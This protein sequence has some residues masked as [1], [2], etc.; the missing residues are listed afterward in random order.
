MNLLVILN[1]K[2]DTPAETFSQ[3]AIDIMPEPVAMQLL[4]DMADVTKS[5]GSFRILGT[6]SGRVLGAP[7]VEEMTVYLCTLA[8]RGAEN[9]SSL[10]Y[11]GNIANHTEHRIATRLRV[12][13]I[14]MPKLSECFSIDDAIAALVFAHVDGLKSRITCGNIGTLNFYAY[15]TEKDC[16]IAE[17]V[18]IAMERMK[19]KVKKSM[20]RVK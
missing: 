13:S 8:V 4:N 7:A 15:S 16:E 1:G 10:V 6:L 14:C 3:I 11:V 18:K 5:V 19:S 12:R 2:T 17:L 9:T 20:M